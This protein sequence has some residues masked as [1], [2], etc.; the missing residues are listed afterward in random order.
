MVI[1]ETVHF[2]S[3]NL[4]GGSSTASV[5]ASLPIAP[6]QSLMSNGTVQ[7]N[8]RPLIQPAPAS[9]QP[10]PYAATASVMYRGPAVVPTMPVA[11]PPAAAV[12]TARPLYQPTLPNYPP[13]P[14][15]PIAASP[16][17]TV[18]GVALPAEGMAFYAD[19][20]VKS[21]LVSIQGSS[22]MY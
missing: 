14:M 9:I 6:L 3:Q 12:S 13:V 20:M 4:L 19:V 2:N 7:S 8:I 16:S 17:R 21:A 11:Y 18:V 1:L 10:A 22:V 5:G 15:Q